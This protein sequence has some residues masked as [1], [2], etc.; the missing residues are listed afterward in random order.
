MR[1]NDNRAGRPN[2]YLIVALKLVSRENA[3]M[4]THRRAAAVGGGAG[5]ANNQLNCNRKCQLSFLVVAW[6]GNEAE[7]GDARQTEYKSAQYIEPVEEI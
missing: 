3:H 4:V 5:M 7:A 6:P 2:K 1:N